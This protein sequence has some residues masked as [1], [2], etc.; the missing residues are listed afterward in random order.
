LR[1]FDKF[2][3]WNAS[4]LRRK[5]SEGN[6]AT[7]S[8]VMLPVSSPDFMGEYTIAPIPCCAQ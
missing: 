4:A 8:F 3:S 2:G 1:F 6:A 5:S 7:R